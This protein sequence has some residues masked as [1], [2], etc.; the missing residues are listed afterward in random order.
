MLYSTTQKEAGED[1]RSG[2]SSLLFVLFITIYIIIF[3]FI[4]CD[5]D[6]LSGQTTL[7]DKTVYGVENSSTFLECSPKSQRA[8]T[9]WQY[10]HSATDRKQEVGTPLSTV[11]LK[12]DVICLQHL[13]HIIS[14]SNIVLHESLLPQVIIGYLS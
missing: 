6:E 9:Y 14:K 11:E 1:T 12:Q 3:L 7:K 10:Q 2:N 13:K 5:L 4:F 8:M